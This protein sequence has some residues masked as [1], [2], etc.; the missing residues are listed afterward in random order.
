MWV[1]EVNLAI[2]PSSFDAYL[3]WLKPHMAEVLKSPGFL[4][5]ELF[6]RP[7]GQENWRSLSVR[8]MVESHE[9]LD[10]YLRDRAPAL[11]ADAERHFAGQFRA[12]RRILKGLFTIDSSL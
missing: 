5:A 10:N 7:E 8:Y 9:A 12:E 2:H 11:R 6:E 1:Y 3:T 4:S